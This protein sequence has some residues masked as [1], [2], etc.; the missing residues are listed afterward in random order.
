MLINSRRKAIM[1]IGQRK[2]F[3]KQRILESSC[4]KKETFDTKI[5]MISRNSNSKNGPTKIYGRQPLKIFK[6]FKFFKGCL[7]QI[8]TLSILEYFSYENNLPVALPLKREN[9]YYS[10]AFICEIFSRLEK[11]IA[12]TYTC[13]L[14]YKTSCTVHLG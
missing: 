3:Y 5:F 1:F 13:W 12:Y 8:F 4:A 11:Y 6:G 9:R 14:Y 7:P 2:A 10:L